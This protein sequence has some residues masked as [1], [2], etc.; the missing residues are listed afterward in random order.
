MVNHDIKKRNL[1]DSIGHF[2]VLLFV[3]LLRNVLA[4]NNILSVDMES[5]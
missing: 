1:A 4:I 2:Q 3:L 5:D